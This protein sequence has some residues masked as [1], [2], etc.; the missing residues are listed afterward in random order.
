MADMQAA[1]QV[2]RSAEELV[3]ALGQF[4]AGIP[5][6]GASSPLEQHRLEIYDRLWS[7]GPTAPTALCHGLGDPDVQVR[8]NVALFLGAAVMTG[9]TVGDR[10]S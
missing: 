7:L 5:A 4:P 3:Q 10:V 1:A 6:T 8:R 9:M 2:L